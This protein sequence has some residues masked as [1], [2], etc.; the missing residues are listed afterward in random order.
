MGG[1]ISR[2]IQSD[3]NYLRAYGALL[4]EGF[5]PATSSNS[6]RVGG[7][8]VSNSAAVLLATV[9]TPS[10]RSAHLPE[11]GRAIEG[12]LIPV[13]AERSRCGSRSRCGVN[14]TL[15]YL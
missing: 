12:R 13:Y 3:P 2:G 5:S 10:T 14:G 7:A 6:L 11:P 9:A 8:H 1:R 15:P 4:Q